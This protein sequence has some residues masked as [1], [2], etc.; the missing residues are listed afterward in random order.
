MVTRRSPAGRLDIQSLTRGPDR[1]AAHAVA[2]HSMPAPESSGFSACPT[3]LSRIDRRTRCP[4]ARFGEPVFG[5]ASVLSL[6]GQLARWTDALAYANSI[7]TGSTGPADS[8]PL[9]TY[10]EPST[11]SISTCRFRSRKRCCRQSAQH[12]GA[13]AGG[14]DDRRIGAAFE[15]AAQSCLRCRRRARRGRLIRTLTG[16][17]SGARL[18]GSTCPARS[19]GFC[20]RNTAPFSATLRRSRPRPCCARMAASISGNCNSTAARSTSRLPA[21]RLPTG[22]CA[23]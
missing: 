11:H 6:N 21:R 7:S 20:P 3:C 13:P 10:A 9:Q 22:F 18:L 17:A 23:T 5:L 15:F 1:L 19:P 8:W 4:E 2:D 14:A 12:S 16:G